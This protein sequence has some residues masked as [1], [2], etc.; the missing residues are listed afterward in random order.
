MQIRDATTED[1]RFISEIESSCWGGNGASPDDFQEFF[2][3][4][5][6]AEFLQ[7]IEM[8]GSILCFIG[9]FY[10]A[11]GSSINIWNLA[12][13][14]QF[15]RSGHGTRLINHVLLVGKSLKAKSLTLKVSE[16]NVGAIK[17]YQ[18]LG[19]EKI[20]KMEKYY[21]DGSAGFKLFLSI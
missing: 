1:L 9:Y 2:S 17:L 6:Q 3:G 15:R 20:S 19:F 8:N 12:V 11:Q 4:K 5:S 16:N 14:P 13:S 18:N 21:P 7:V 10:D